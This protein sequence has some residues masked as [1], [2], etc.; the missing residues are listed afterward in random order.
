MSGPVHALGQV[1][2]GTWSSVYQIN[3]FPERHLAKWHVAALSQVI[4]Q[5]VND[6]ACHL[7][8]VPLQT[9]NP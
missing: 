1:V 4:P 5:T 7:T 3:N 6:I 2:G 8:Q 9:L